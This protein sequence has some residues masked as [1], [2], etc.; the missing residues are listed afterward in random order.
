MKLKWWLYLV[1]ASLVAFALPMLFMFGFE[2]VSAYNLEHQ[3]N[4]QINQTSFK[5][6]Y[7]PY[8]KQHD[9]VNTKAFQHHTTQQLTDISD[10]QGAIRKNVGYYTGTLNGVYYNLNLKYT[11]GTW[12]RF[13]LPH[14]HIV[15]LTKY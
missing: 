7:L 9:R 2:E 10:F 11:S 8:F 15:G 5:T 13:G 4:T 1:L 3:L 14:Y 6:H 12:Q